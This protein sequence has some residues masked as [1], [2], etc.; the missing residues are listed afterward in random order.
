[1]EKVNGV[2][3]SQPRAGYRGKRLLDLASVILLAAP[4]ALISAFCGAAV[5]LSSGG[6]ALFRQERVGGDAPP[7]PILKFRPMV[8]ANNPL[9]PEADRITT[10]GRWLR[11]SSLDELP[12][13]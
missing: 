1:M 8:H 10:V 11:R 3:C 5:R 2:P 7:F 6:P 12:Q 13:L 4:A 9:H